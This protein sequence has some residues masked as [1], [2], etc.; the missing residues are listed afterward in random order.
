MGAP[1]V[2]GSSATAVLAY[3]GIAVKMLVDQRLDAQLHTMFMVDHQPESAP[4]RTTTPSQ[5]SYYILEGEVDVVAD[6]DRYTLRPGDAFWTGTGRAHASQRDAGTARQA[7]LD[8][9][10]GTAA[11]PLVQAPAGLGL[12]RP[13]PRRRYERGRGMS[14][15]S[16][17]RR[18]ASSTTSSSTRGSTAR[19]SSS[20]S[21]MTSS[22]RS[23]SRARST[24]RRLY[25]GQEAIATGFAS[26][27]R[28]STPRGH[29]PRSLPRARARHDPQAWSTRCS[30]APPT[31]RRPR[32]LDERHRSA[33]GS[34]GRT[35]SSAGASPRPRARPAR[36]KRTRGDVGPRSSATAR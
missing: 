2:S 29:L 22:N 13:A 24:G 19:C 5:E 28:R 34:S 6:D 17:C 8:L 16:E 9:C 27:P 14:N 11:A 10:A 15:V 23:S 12:P 21:S 20:G 31:S 26:A 1:T 30:A 36:L 3:S 7:A 33:T 18:R 4:T 32:R 35:G 25:A